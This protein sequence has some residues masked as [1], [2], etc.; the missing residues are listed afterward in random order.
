M[1]IPF[2]VFTATGC[3]I[4]LTINNPRYTIPN[5]P[6]EYYIIHTVLAIHVYQYLVQLFLTVPAAL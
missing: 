4:S 5:S 6:I 1:P 2:N 3:D